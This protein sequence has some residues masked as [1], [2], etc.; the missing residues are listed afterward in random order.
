[1]A[2]LEEIDLPAGASLGKIGH[3]AWAQISESDPA[4]ALFAKFLLG[5]EQFEINT[6]KKLSEKFYGKARQILIDEGYGLAKFESVPVSTASKKK[7]EST[8]EKIR[9]ENDERIF[10]ESLESFKKESD[11]RRIKKNDFFDFVFLN[12]IRRV[13]ER[14]KEEILDFLDFGERYFKAFE[15][16]HVLD[17]DFVKAKAIKEMKHFWLEML[18]NPFGSAKTF[19]LRKN[20]QTVIDLSLGSEE[21]S[22]LILNRSGLGSGKTTTAIKIALELWKKHRASPGKKACP[23][24][25]YVCV[26]KL[27]RTSVAQ[28]A[29]AVGIPFGFC[30][31]T[32]GSGIKY[33]WKENSI[34]TEKNFLNSPLIISDYVSSQHFYGLLNAGMTPIEGFTSDQTILFLDEPTIG[35]EKADNPLLKAFFS[36]YKNF[37]P[38]RTILASATLPAYADLKL[39]YD[40][41]IDKHSAK[42]IEIVDKEVH[43]PLDLAVDSN[44][45]VPSLTFQAS[46]YVENPYLR[47]LL[48][49]RLLLENL[50]RVDTTMF[51]KVR[52]FFVPD[53]GKWNA[54]GMAVANELIGSTSEG[55]V[56]YVFE[57][58]GV[59]QLGKGACHLTGGCLVVMKRPFEEIVEIVE[60][61]LS[62]QKTSLKALEKTLIVKT[63]SFT[64]SEGTR[65]ERQR[66]LSEDL[67][68]DWSF[69]KFLQINSISH[70]RRFS[71][72][73]TSIR[74]Q[75]PINFGDISEVSDLRLAVLLAMG[76]GIYDNRMNADYLETVSKLMSNGR[77]AFVV[78][79]INSVAYG[80]NAP[81]SHLILKDSEVVEAHSSSTIQQLFAR[82]G[83]FVY[84]ASFVYSIEK[85][86][87]VIQEKDLR[88]IQNLLNVFEK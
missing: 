79:E 20:Q 70:Q 77:L 80:T 53:L 18:K 74:H 44:Y 63:N 67:R 42:I 78:A 34:S 4:R 15:P 35:A 14:P 65:L 2:S 83:R 40:F 13:S 72:G 81:F 68:S 86:T 24:V 36:L 51:R 66:E 27:V 22:F 43:I 3:Q 10:T 48:S 64:V 37:A 23:K 62:G 28:L 17:F 49:K 61:F 69:P 9:R 85:I 46:L 55:K 57:S 88:E 52:D 26:N 75:E 11:Y 71:P 87:R 41:F 1:M 33:S 29:F 47:R 32:P 58:F 19:K 7:P 5:D 56:P 45:W 38:P 12:F 6:D 76:I 60:A 31:Y 21:N 39:V 50:D 54:E 84:S 8:K 73:A 25:V 59:D 82:V 16:Y 30:V